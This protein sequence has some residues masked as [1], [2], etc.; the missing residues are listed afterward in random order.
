MRKPNLS[1]AQK[2]KVLAPAKDLETLEAELAEK[3]NSPENSLEDTVLRLS[4]Y[5]SAVEM[6]IK[7]TFN[8]RVWV[9]AE[10]RNLSSKG[11]HYYFELAEKDDD[12]KVI[13]SCRGNLWRFKAARVLAKFERSN[14]Y[15]TRARL[16]RATQG[17]GRVPCAIWLFAHYRRY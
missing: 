4:D 9:K 2:T 16:N 1:N 8:H 3:E 7:Q 11:G 15:A 12:G 17:I 5:L 14:R 6:V 13:A 10:V